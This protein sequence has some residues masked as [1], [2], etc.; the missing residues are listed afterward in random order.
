MREIGRK[1][2]YS[3]VVLHLVGWLIISLSSIL[4]IPPELGYDGRL[5]LYRF[6]VPFVLA[7]AFYIAHFVLTPLLFYRH[8][9]WFFLASLLLIVLLLP[10]L[11]HLHE[12]IHL[13]EEQLGWMPPEIPG[14]HPVPHMFSRFVFRDIVSLLLS[15]M[16][17]TIAQMSIHGYQ[18]EVQ[19]QEMEKQ[20]TRDELENLRFQ[21][22]PHF[23]LNTL[24]N[25]YALIAFN[26]QK[27]QKALL[28]L[29]GLSRSMLYG[30]K[31]NSIP[32]KEEIQFL[33]DYINLM[34]L[35]LNDTVELKVNFDIDPNADVHVAPYVFITLV[36]NAF[37]HGISSTRPSFIHINITARK[38]QMTCAIDN[39]NYPKD[40]TDKS[41]HGI[42]LMQVERR[43]KLAYG[44]Q[45]EWLRG[46]DEKTNTYHSKIL[47]YDTEMRDYR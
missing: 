9:R 12:L 24:N 4:F 1:A 8:R 22:R 26:P 11:Q 33:T 45:Y 47:I 29:S 43:L 2:T 40:L 23:L 39:S 31:T 6:S 28:D 15:V 34:R 25:I 27:A 32:I 17:G 35:R 10:L 7:V 3:I 42:G 41:G 30:M 38:N 18:L 19:R 20:R 36:E 16:V 21:I 14:A 37:K 44:K 13:R 5:L 46:V